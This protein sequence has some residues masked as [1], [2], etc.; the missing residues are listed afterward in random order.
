VTPDD[1]VIVLRLAVGV[2][3]AWSTA[4]KLGHPMRFVRGVAEYRLLPRGVSYLVGAVLIPAEGA[5]AAAHLTGSYLPFAIPMCL[6]LLAAFMAAAAVQLLRG[7]PSPCF[8]FDTAGDELISGRTII[9]LSLLMACEGVLLA[10]L[11]NP[12]IDR[13]RM[14]AAVYSPRDGLLALAWVAI[15]LSAG[16]WIVQSQDVTDLL[17]QRRGRYERQTG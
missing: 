12:G 11:S 9:R 10:P 5:I 4:A 7:R 2:V 6:A 8:C 15:V 13:A 16:R 17:F 14:L 1:L 3:F